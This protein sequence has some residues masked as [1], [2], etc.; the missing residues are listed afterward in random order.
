LR[1]SVLMS[2]LI[3][4]VCNF[5]LCSDNDVVEK[6]DV[7]KFSFLGNSLDYQSVFHQ[8]P[9]IVDLINNN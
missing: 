4:P 2:K 3:A 6:K 1:H 7:T 9:V 5:L 8:I